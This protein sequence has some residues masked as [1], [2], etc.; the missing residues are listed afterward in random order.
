MH[1]IDR[2]HYDVILA[3][4]DVVAV[5]PGRLALMCH[6]DGG[7]R[8]GKSTGQIRYRHEHD[9]NNVL[10]GNGRRCPWHFV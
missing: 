8:A 7:K 6:K 4:P 5:D 10:Y 9:K 2:L 1:C 3:K